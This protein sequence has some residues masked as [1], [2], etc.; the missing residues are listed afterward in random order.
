MKN[1]EMKGGKMEKAD[2]NNQDS[3]E[4]YEKEDEKKMSYSRN[5]RTYYKTKS[6]ALSV[7][8]KGDRIY[9]DAFEKAYYIVRP[10]RRKGF[11]VF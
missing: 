5:G 7:T 4:E 10:Q 1:E 9:Y 11:W 2:L 3:I 8:R 6:E